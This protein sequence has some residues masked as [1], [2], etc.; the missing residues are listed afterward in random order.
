MKFN[1][2]YSNLCEAIDKQSKDCELYQE[3]LENVPD[4]GNVFLAFFQIHPEFP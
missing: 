1:D 2:A 3:G 4:R